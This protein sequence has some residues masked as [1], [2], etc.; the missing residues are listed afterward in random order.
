[1]KRTTTKK[2]LLCLLGSVSAGLGGA[3]AANAQTLAVQP[4]EPSLS[5]DIAQAPQVLTQDKPSLRPSATVAETGDI[6]LNQHGF[7]PSAPKLAVLIRSTQSPVGFSVI[8][9]S[10]T[11]V[12]TGQSKNF[13]LNTASGH[14]VHHLDFSTLTPSGQGY[15]VVVGARQSPPFAIGNGLYKSLARDA[16][17]YFYQS[18]AGQAVQAAYVPTTTP[19]LSRPAGHIG[20]TARCFSG[21][22]KRGTVWPDCPDIAGPGIAD[23]DI[24]G[25][26]YDAGDLG[27]Y[28]VNAA[29]TVFTLLNYY[30]SQHKVF[31][32]CGGNFKDGDQ[33]LPEAGD[34]M[35][36]LLNEARVG[37]EFML[38]MQ[39]KTTAPLP[40]AIGNQP[41][42]GPLNITSKSVPGMMF[43]K[44]H[45]P[46]WGSLG[47]S[48]AQDTQP[49]YLYPPSTQAT[50]GLA[51]IGAQC[52][53][54]FSQIDPELSARCLSAASR[55]FSAAQAT[56]NAYAY[57]NFNG[58]G[59][60]D[61]LSLDDERLWAATE[62]W[63]S[64]GEP[65]YLAQIESVLGDGVSG[66]FD[67]S[68]AR[69][70]TWAHVEYAA[71]LSLAVSAKAKRPNQRRIWESKALTDLGTLARVYAA[72]TDSQGMAIPYGKAAYDW[73][74]NG[75]LLSRAMIMATHG[76]ASAAAKDRTAMR[77]E[78]GNMMD[79]LL[80]RNPLSQS[81][82]TGYGSK[83]M[84][85]PHHRFW[86]NTVDANFPAPP[87]GVI[88]GGPNNSSMV[89]PIAIQLE[90]NCIGQTCWDDHV[91]AYS[92]NEVAI[93][94]NAPLVW[95]SGWLNAQESQCREPVRTP[96]DISDKL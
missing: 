43:H 53:R 92:L 67:T 6:V 47:R 59:P 48:P 20:E 45:N 11:V 30:E 28:S 51:A 29:L 35:N 12:F 58:G 13:G 87:A 40:L 8:D 2:L 70:L 76:D 19:P 72:Q 39:V 95:V 64:T 85:R 75:I 21:L 61:D 62:L 50:L 42:S 3:E 18:R 88:S 10:G 91:E 86:A 9:G 5:Q 84:L 94:W 46:D 80:G 77:A 7:A 54:I 33:P 66:G 38:K 25:G 68:G 78:V 17:S 52:A 96:A 27:K 82:I 32:R 56:S 4:L 36:D 16:L 81:Y 41:S 65:Q 60:Y 55:A 69:E 89:D 14:R 44:V 79:Y 37:I 22:D 71:L 1:M 57:D 23:K 31:P 63:L 90:G 34:G 15:R 26:W 83:P 24:D 74:S 73:G 93:N 49:R